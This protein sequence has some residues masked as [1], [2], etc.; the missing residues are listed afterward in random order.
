MEKNL[1]WAIKTLRKIVKES[2]IKGQKHIDLTLATN[3]NRNEYE[4]ALAITRLSV[5]KGE[6]SEVELKDRLGLN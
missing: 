4:H 3:D 2:H 1:D 5:T 6:I